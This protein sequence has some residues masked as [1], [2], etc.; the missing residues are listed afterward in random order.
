MTHFIAKV[1]SYFYKD[2]NQNDPV[3]SFFFDTKSGTRKKV[4]MKALRKAQSDQKNII[5]LAKKKA[6]I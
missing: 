4:Y 6:R 5:E 2:T 3:F 1:T